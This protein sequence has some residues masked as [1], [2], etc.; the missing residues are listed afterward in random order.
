MIKTLTLILFLLISSCYWCHE[1]DFPEPMCDCPKVC[2]FQKP[3]V[4]CDSQKPKV[5]KAVVK[6]CKGWRDENGKCTPWTE[7]DKKI[8]KWVEENK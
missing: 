4:E 1:S 8:K 3:K 7:E 2:D 5:E 6:L